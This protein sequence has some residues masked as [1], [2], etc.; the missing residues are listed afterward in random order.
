MQYGASGMFL[1]GKGVLAWVGPELAKLKLGFD[2]TDPGHLLLCKKT[3]QHNA[4][5]ALRKRF[6][7]TLNLFVTLDHLY[8]WDLEEDFFGDDFSFWLD[9]LTAPQRKI[10]MSVFW[11]FSFV[12]YNFLFSFL[13]FYSLLLSSPS[14]SFKHVLLYCLK[15]EC[16][17]QGRRYSD[18]CDYY[19][20]LRRLVT[21]K[22]Y[23]LLFSKLE[24][25]L[26]RVK[27]IV[28]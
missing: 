16:V 2:V 28:Y 20:F 19:E 23:E 15:F 27:Q 25:F 17:S 11:L 8:E 13:S 18:R 1:S 7:E 5:H 6:I 9:K 3:V 21:N 10:F 22:A 26:C 12:S 14:F 4:Y 24:Y